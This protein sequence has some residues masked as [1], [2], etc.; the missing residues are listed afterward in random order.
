ME[1]EPPGKR[2]YLVGVTKASA[3]MV[4][5]PDDAESRGAIA[6]GDD[7]CLMYEI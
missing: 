3:S 7:A 4:L 6:V 2:R 5:G 1:N